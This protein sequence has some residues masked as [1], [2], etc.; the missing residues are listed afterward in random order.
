RPGAV[1]S[2]ATVKDKRCSSEPDLVLAITHDRGELLRLETRSADEGTVDVTLGHDRSDV[3]GLDRSAVQDPERLGEVLA[4]LL[5]QPA[6]DR[7]ADFL[8]VLGGGD[9]TGADG[10]DG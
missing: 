5:G 2:P 9:L 3:R 8:R 1:T 6:P 7:R 10:P 4:V